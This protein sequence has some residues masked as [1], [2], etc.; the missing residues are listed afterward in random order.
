MS[1]V[2]FGHCPHCQSDE[3][4]VLQSGPRDG[5]GRAA[6]NAGGLRSI[7]LARVVCLQCGSVRE[8]VTDREQLNSLRKKYGGAQPSK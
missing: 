2:N 7:D 6:I 8:W 3:T 4:V 5:H 1:D